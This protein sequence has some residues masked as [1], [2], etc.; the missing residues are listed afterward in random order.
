MNSF[1]VS[2]TRLSKSGWNVTVKGESGT[3]KSAV[4]A[5][6]CPKAKCG[7][8]AEGYVA[9]G[10]KLEANSLQLNSTG[11][12]ITGGIGSTGTAKLECSSSC[13]VDSGS[14]V[15]VA[16]S[17]NAEGTWTAGSWSATSLK[18]SA[19]TTLKALPSEEIYRV[20]ILWTLS[21]GP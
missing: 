15:K 2:D 18:L 13:N 7:S 3:G 1:S 6:Y 9:G 8:T 11:A 16:S 12:S 4:F 17:A 14:E 20:N 21:S 5:Q 19:P 10:S